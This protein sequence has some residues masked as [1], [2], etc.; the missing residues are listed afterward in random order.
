MATRKR[1]TKHRPSPKPIKPQTTEKLLPLSVWQGGVVVSIFVLLAIVTHL[2][3]LHAAHVEDGIHHLGSVG[4]VQMGESN[5]GEFLWSGWNEHLLPA[6]KLWY[7][8]MWKV[9]GLQPMGWHVAVL[10]GHGVSAALLFFFLRH[11]LA[12]TLA[13]A[14][15]ALFWAVASIGGWDNPL[16]WISASHLT[17]GFMWLLA[18]M[19]CVSGYHSPH[20]TRWALG[21]AACQ[22]MA[23]FTMGALWVLTPILP[24]QYA[25][26]EHRRPLQI[27]RLRT[28]LL[29]WLVPFLML[30]LLQTMFSI[31][32]RSPEIEAQW[33][34]DLLLGLVRAGAEFQISLFSLW[35]QPVGSENTL[36]TVGAAV[37]GVVAIGVFF[38][39][40]KINR[41]LLLVTFGLTMVY[42]IVVHTMRAAYPDDRALIWGRYAYIPVFAWSAAMAA[43]TALPQFRSSK[44]D[45][46]CLISIVLLVLPF[47]VVRQYETARSTRFE[48]NDTFSE[49]YERWEAYQQIFRQLAATA[50]EE[51]KKVQL[52][53]FPL[54]I[55]PV[56]TARQLYN[57]IDLGND[58]E[59]I[60]FVTPLEMDEE[61]HQH[62][63]QLIKS[64]GNPQ[65]D[66]WYSLLENTPQF[67]ECLVD[68]SAV[69][70]EHNQVAMIP[71]AITMPIY[72]EPLSIQAI[73]DLLFY[74]GLPR[75]EFIDMQDVTEKNASD[76]LTLLNEVP[77]PMARHM[78]QL[79]TELLENQQL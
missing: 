71:N 14:V 18:A 28:W 74:E 24:V 53:E 7:F 10:V 48:L 69:A 51:D 2:P 1:R 11:Y 42:T 22:T 9:F 77:G 3:Y 49:T 41:R 37:V 40:P 17:F 72:D 12:S 66:Q 21:M 26:L 15:G 55:P 13:A 6:W 65:K 39:V 47:Y 19:C 5:L 56:I 78:E 64:I 32:S 60:S 27:K 8:T 20:S 4:S 36:N 16:L 45:Q 54:L 75:V 70:A 63:L 50:K 25:I 61:N 23:V 57:V 46:R 68:L 35:L 34:P 29:A 62:A 38:L 58:T 73:S 52:T 43:L 44:F 30:G 33:T 79:I 76:L 31:S 59:W 67:S